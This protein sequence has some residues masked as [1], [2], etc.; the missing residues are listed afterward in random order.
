MVPAPCDL[1]EDRILAESIAQAV[2]VVVGDRVLAAEVAP[3]VADGAKA[4]LHVA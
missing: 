1:P 3:S 4:R 2:L